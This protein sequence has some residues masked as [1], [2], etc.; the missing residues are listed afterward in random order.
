MGWV[1]HFEIWRWCGSD[2]SHSH[3]RRAGKSDVGSQEEERGGR[4]CGG[5]PLSSCCPSL[6][7]QLS[8]LSAQHE[9]RADIVRPALPA[10]ARAGAAPP[11]PAAAQRG[12]NMIKQGPGEGPLDHCCTNWPHTPQPIGSLHHLHLLSGDRHQTVIKKLIIW[13]KRLSSVPDGHYFSHSK[14]HQ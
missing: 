4:W 14:L 10:A 3:G 9:L 11:P 13:E 5:C 12:W 7:T 6:L 1:F 2:D 8:S